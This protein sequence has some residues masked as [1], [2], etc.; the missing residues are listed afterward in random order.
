MSFQL[1][2]FALPLTRKPTVL[3]PTLS[4]SIFP[5]KLH[6][7]VL[8]GFKKSPETLTEH[9]AGDFIQCPLTEKR[10]KSAKNV[11]VTG[12]FLYFFFT[13][14]GGLRLLFNEEGSA[15]MFLIL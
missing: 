13:V 4:F 12:E 5:S 9:S 3:P 11:D 8:F 10:E 14:I 7:W 2:T 1:L 6:Q 15:K